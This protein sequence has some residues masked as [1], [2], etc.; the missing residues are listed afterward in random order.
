M[1]I[2]SS[3]SKR[4]VVFVTAPSGG[5]KT[6]LGE[7]LKANHEFLHFDVDSWDY[8][9]DPFFN[10]SDADGATIKKLRE[11]RS[12]QFAA[13]MEAMS[14][15]IQR[16]L[17]GESDFHTSAVDEFYAMLGADIKKTLAEF[18]NRDMVISR[19]VYTKRQ[20]DLVRKHIP[21]VEFMIL[22]V[23]ASLLQDRIWNRFVRRASDFGMTP[24]EY[25][26]SRSTPEKRITVEHLVDTWMSKSAVGWE[27]ASASEPRTFSIDVTA[28]MTTE[29]VQRRAEDLL[30]L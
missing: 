15:C 20:R 25:C 16:M 18:P 21:D 9:G 30:G 28:A 6:T 4:R 17:A 27:A 29:D 23:D 5:G 22:E 10:M 7:A 24:E 19:M 8:V 3:I 14:V 12:P 2:D 13:A 11:S 1:G 26:E